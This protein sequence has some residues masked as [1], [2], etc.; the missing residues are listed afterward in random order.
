[1][2]EAIPHLTP[3]AEAGARALGETVIPHLAPAAEAHAAKL[4]GEIHDSMKEGAYNGTKQA[5]SEKIQK[6]KSSCTVQ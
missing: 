2:Q 3:A 1:M 5:I 4:G 6:A